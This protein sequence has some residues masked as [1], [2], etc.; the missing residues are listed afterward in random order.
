MSPSQRHSL[1]KGQGEVTGLWNCGE[2]EAA[3]HL[4]AREPL[5][6]PARASPRPACPPH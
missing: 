2:V 6:V 1:D 3:L 4:P 5:P